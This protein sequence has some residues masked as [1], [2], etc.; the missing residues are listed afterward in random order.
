MG[1][2]LIFQTLV[3]LPSLKSIQN[4]L[5]KSVATTDLLHYNIALI[6]SHRIFVLTA[7]FALIFPIVEIYISTVI[8]KPAFRSVFLALIVFLGQWAYC[9]ILSA[10][11]LFLIL[12]CKLASAYVDELI[13][14]H[15]N[16]L[17]TLEKYN[18]VRIEIKNRVNSSLILNYSIIVVSIVNFV[19]FLLLIVFANFFNGWLAVLIGLYFVLLKEL[20]FLVILFFHSAE[21]NEKSDRLTIM[22]G[23]DVWD[24]EHFEKCSNRFALFAN[25]EAQRISY[26]LAGLRMN[27]A[28]IRRQLIG[29]TLATVIAVVKAVVGTVVN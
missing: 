12:D 13:T 16:G 21:V 14:L 25:A 7:I 2:S 6:W 29:W 18:V 27:Y 1:V 28:D 8:F 17:L 22:L 15:K 26:P 11:V 19:I 24:L 10:N 5:N 9:C 23:T 20:P 4:R 3:I